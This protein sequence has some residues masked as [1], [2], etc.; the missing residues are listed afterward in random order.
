MKPCLKSSL[1]TSAP[2]A[3]FK[4][5]FVIFLKVFT[6]T[7]GILPTLKYIHIYETYK[8]LLIKYNKCAI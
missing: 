7:L 5:I 6:K 1:V 3:K 4:T 2:F 8:F